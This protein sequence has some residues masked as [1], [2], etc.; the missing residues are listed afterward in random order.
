MMTAQHLRD[1][2]PARR[3][4][5][6]VA[7]ILDTRATLIDESIDLHDR[8]MGTLFS[9]AKRNHTDR[10]QQSGKAINDWNTCCP[11]RFPVEWSYGQDSFVYLDDVKIKPAGR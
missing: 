1:L 8:F 10:F 4:A 3:Y 6:L 2:E 9:T 7:V 11:S 5:T